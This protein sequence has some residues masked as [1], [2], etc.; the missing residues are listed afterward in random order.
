MYFNPNFQ[1]NCL[2][3]Y[4]ELIYDTTLVDT[5]DFKE[6]YNLIGY[7]IAFI[8]CYWSAAKPNDYHQFNYSIEIDWNIKLN[9]HWIS[10]NLGII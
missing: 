1:I 6:I 9:E 3:W 4:T 5:K 7:C 2:S 10:R 8:D